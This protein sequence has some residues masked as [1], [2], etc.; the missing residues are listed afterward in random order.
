MKEPNDRGLTEEEYIEENMYVLEEQ[1]GFD[2]LTI[3][4][5]ELERAEEREAET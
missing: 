2:R 4:T 3:E 1:M 5:E